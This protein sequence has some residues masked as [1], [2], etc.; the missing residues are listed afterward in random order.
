[1]SAAELSTV[2]EERAQ[3][4]TSTLPEER[5]QRI[6]S[7]LPEER[8]Q[9]A[10]RRAAERCLVLWFPGWPVTAWALAEGA[11]ANRPIAVMAANRVVA[12]SPEASAEGVVTGQRRREAQARCPGLLVLPAD[13][14][15]DAREFDPVLECI[16]EIAPGVQVIWPGACALRPRGLARYV[17]SE[18]E[19]AE[20]LLEAVVA[21]LGLTGGRAGIADG[22]FTALQAAYAGDP[23]RIVPPGEGAAFLAPLP[24]TRLGD[25]SLSALLPRLGVHTLGAFAALGQDAVRDRFGRH[26]ERLH[27][28]ASGADPSVVA[29]RTPPPEL[30]RQ[31]G[32]E[33]PLALVDQV[34]FTAR[35]TVEEFIAGLSAAGLACTELR[36]EVSG[37]RDELV[38]RTW[39]TPGVFDAPAVVDRL[40]WQLQAAAGSRLHSAVT[41]VRLEPLVVDALAHH[42]PGLFGSGTDERVH[43]VLSRVQA[44]LGHDG[45]ATARIGGGRWLAERQELVAWG[46]RPVSALAATPRPQGARDAPGT[47]GEDAGPWP[48]RLPDP[49]PSSVFTWPR[50]VQLLTREGTAVGLDDRDQLRGV[51]TALLLEDERRTV[52]G[53]AGPWPIDERSWDPVRHRRASRFQVVDGAGTAWLLVLQAGRWWAEGRYD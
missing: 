49:L 41:G 26:G 36:I 25:E 2:P 45:V 47:S 32:F 35:A 46:D 30:S 44:M 14:G 16:E 24:V 11:D 42:V 17:G 33:P 5:A 21:S 50:P 53:W 31:I 7:T 1:M 51:P 18:E 3:R 19:A 28:L 48:G 37:E 34:A 10:S 22:R 12:C 39:G 27:A 4:V 23:V 9:R 52:I 15:R 43:H 38:A 20:V 6:P 13:E 29:A 40:R 8:A